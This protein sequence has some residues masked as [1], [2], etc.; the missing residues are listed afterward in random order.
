M[1]GFVQQGA[2][3]AV[4]SGTNQ[5]T[6][7]SVASGN[8]L[9]AVYAV[10]NGNTISAPTDSAGQTWTIRGQFHNSTVTIVLAYLLSANAGTHT[11]TWATQTSASE[12][13]ISEWN[14]ITAVGNAAVSTNGSSVTTLT[15]A[16]YTPSQANEVII[17]ACMEFGTS[18]PDNIHCSTTAFQAIGSTTDSGGAGKNCIAVEQNGS[19]FGVLEAN[20][21]IV[22]STSAVTC[23]WAWTNANAAVSIIG[24]FKYTPAGALPFSIDNGN[25]WPNPA[26]RKRAIDPFDPKNLVL[27]GIAVAAFPL[28]QTFDWP[29][30]QLRKAAPQLVEEPNLLMSRLVGSLPFAQ[31]NDNDWQ[32]PA[33]RKSAPQ[34]VEEPNLLFSTLTPGRIFAEY[35]GNDWQNPQRAKVAPQIFEYPNLVLKFGASVALPFALQTDWPNPARPK[36]PPQLVDEPNLVL[37][38]GVAQAW[39]VR[40]ILDGQRVP[41]RLAP[42]IVEE[43]NLLLTKF[44]TQPLPFGPQPEWPNP[45]LR[46]ASAQI[47][48]QPN[49]ALRFGSPQPLPFV[50]PF[51]WS[52]PQRAKVAPQLVE[53]PNLAIKFGSPQALPFPALDWPNPQRAKLAPQLVDYPNL[54]L[55]FGTSQG[56]QIRPPMDGQ[57]V[58]ARTA[59]Q[60]VEEPNLLL[61]FNQASL[62]LPFG[63]QPEWPNPAP[64]KV[65]P[66]VVEEP[67]LILNKFL[68]PIWQKRALF[69]G[70]RQLTKA[71][72]QIFEFPNLVL[73]LGPGAAALPFIPPDWPNPGQRLDQG[74]RH[75]HTNISYYAPA[76]FP[77]IEWPNP[78]LAKRAPQIEPYVNTLTL[79]TKAPFQPFVPFDW[80]NPQRAKTPPQ[81]EPLPGLLLTLAHYP[82]FGPYDWPNPQLRKVPPQVV[83][84]PNLL[85]HGFQVAQTFVPLDWPNPLRA[86]VPPQI[87]EYPNLVLA[88]IAAYPHFGPYDWQNPQRKAAPQIQADSQTLLLF[89]SPS[90]QLFTPFDWANPARP[91]PQPQAEISPNFFFRGAVP[92]LV[93]KGPFEWVNPAPR[94]PSQPVSEGSN[95]V[96]QGPTPLLP[97]SPFD[98]PNPSRPKAPALS[99][100]YPN[101]ALTQTTIPT[102]FGY[103]NLVALTQTST[104]T[105]KSTYLVGS[106]CTVTASYF[107]LARAPFVPAAVSYRIDDVVTGAN[108][109]PWTAITPAF[110]NEITVTSTQNSMVSLTRKSEQH[111][112]LLMITDNAGNTMYARTLYRIRLGAYQWAA[113]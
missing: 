84:Y 9:I 86:K 98:W 92:S 18:N 85:L 5:P 50:P 71:A 60:L 47:V 91:R 44:Q 83:D 34:I 22:T 28:V 25:D 27:A 33:P 113:T 2:I 109:V 14:G 42:Q 8:T 90:G 58:P 78:Q 20:A 3:H 64:R 43:P 54:V 40:G 21:D 30:P 95:L 93:A 75:S 49:L 12:S 31:F 80:S 63:P 57:R 53:Y 65:A 88:G 51:D 10:N 24:G 35:N 94:R 55:E 7:A 111:Q 66:Q 72:P 105:A 70:Q 82:G 41:G 77:V 32:N 15:S 56:W 39:Q 81:V 61:R 1:S 99:F 87:V 97:F 74:A 19:S 52:N 112:L 46:K 69:D 102:P 48:E 29:N 79:V 103:C 17:A 45:L 59:P 11:L 16:S 23:T 89:R 6:I 62:P 13:G 100:E 76:I 96:L 38:L 73:K 101:L 68:V 104:Q 36:T 4:A 108:L 26:P 67:N 106:S 110:I 107:S 37:A